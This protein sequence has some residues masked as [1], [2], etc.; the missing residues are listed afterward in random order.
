M[1]NSLSRRLVLGAATAATA[2]L[3]LAHTMAAAQ[4]PP[5]AIG[6]SGPKDFPRPTAPAA[7]K[8]QDSIGFAIVGLGSYALHQ[9]MPRF[10]QSKRAHIAALVS[11]NPEK[12][13]HVGQAY[14]IAKDCLYSYEDFD[15]IAANKKVDAVYIVL[16][17][18]LHAEWTQKAF[19]AG[20]HVLCE[21]PMALSSL[22]CARMIAASE[23]ANKKLMIAYRCHFEPHNM[24]A[25]ELMK[26]KALGDVRL[27]RSD[28]Q[29][30]FW[31]TTPAQNWRLNRALAG[32]GPLEDY[33]LYGLQ[34]ALYLTD[35]MPEMITASGLKPKGDARFS[36]VYAHISS[37]LHFPSGA[38][39][40][41]STSYDAHGANNI[42]VT[43]TQGKLSMDPAVGYG[44][45]KMRLN[46]DG[47]ASRDLTPGSPEVQFAA[48]LDHLADAIL[49]K[50][51]ILT[52]GEMGLRD[53]R[54]I[55]AIYRSVITGKSV[56]L[57]QDATLRAR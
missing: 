37:Q 47:Q 50:K 32:G 57:N 45:H 38:V 11:G 34:A 39:A 46:Q 42:F 15:Q 16:P 43:G 54:L 35:E 36:E 27:I 1:E 18:G 19:A 8:S 48:Q 23:R 17:T 53:I 4:T 12:L 21:K 20:K 2:G 3:S 6:Q 29:Y 55:E 14:G 44:G 49:D 33:G 51:P 13:Q 30:R 9:M 52:P 56:S 5:R 22:E 10:S 26:Q 40:Q 31:P 41:L 25:I 7:P 24:L 28:Q